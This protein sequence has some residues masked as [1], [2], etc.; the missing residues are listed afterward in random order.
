MSSTRLDLI[1]QHPERGGAAQSFHQQPVGH[2]AAGVGPLRLRTGAIELSDAIGSALAAGRQDPGGASHAGGAAARS[3]DARSGRGAVRAGAVQSAGQCEQVCT[4]RFADHHQGMAGRRQRGRAGAG[5][6]AWH[7]A[8]RSGARVRQVLPRR[9]RRSAARRH[10]AGARDLPRLRRGDARQHRGDQSH[11]PIGCGVHHDA[12]GVRR[13]PR[14]RRRRS[15]DR[16]RRT[17]TGSR[18]G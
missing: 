10:W 3:A 7:S 16:R 15:N 18:G 2:D 9:W 13:R 17:G 8:G 1:A 14:G 6:G 4:G 12:A 11:R 5:R